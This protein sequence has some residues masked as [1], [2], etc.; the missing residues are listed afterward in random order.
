MHGLKEKGLRGST[1]K[2]E[3]RE[4]FSILTQAL[5]ASWNCSKWTLEK[6]GDCHV[7]RAPAPDKAMNLYP[8]FSFVS[9]Q[10]TAGA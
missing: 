8:L 2:K 4:A 9:I 1:Y 3:S 6:S 5:L 10:V 7:K